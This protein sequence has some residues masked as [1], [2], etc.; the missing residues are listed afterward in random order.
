LFGPGT[1]FWTL[2]GELATPVFDGFS[3]LHRER[4]AREGL[5]QAAALYKAAVITA[6]Q[7]VADTLKALQ[8]DADAVKVALYAQDAA[9]HSLQ[10]ARSQLELGQVAYLSLL[11]AEQTF[12]L[13]K[14]AVVQAQAARLT[15]TAGLFQALGGGWWHRHDVAEVQGSQ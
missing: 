13:A 12:Q 4:A 14:L 2:A 6:F 10:I 8:V 11:N 15:D 7:N 1:A 3:L 9:A 5:K